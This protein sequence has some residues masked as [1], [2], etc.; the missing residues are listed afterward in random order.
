MRYR[1]SVKKRCKTGLYLES[2][3]FFLDQDL[4]LAGVIRLSDNALEFHALHQRRRAVISDLQAALDIA[5]GSLA[6]A[7]DDGDRLGE[8]IATTIAA[9]PG[10]IEHRAGFVVPLFG[11]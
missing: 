8:Q 4:A 5:G 10:R 7:F 2:A 3:F 9:H 11:S 6:V 1:F